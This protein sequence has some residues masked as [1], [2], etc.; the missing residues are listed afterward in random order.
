MA[1]II[2]YH[3]APSRS[4]MVLW[5]LEELGQPYEVR[6]LDMKAGENR[7]PAFLAINPMGK[8]PTIIHKGV[9][10]SEAPAICLHLADCYP[11]AGL[12]VPPDD[13]RRGPM[14]QW[15]FFG[16]GCVEPAAIDKAMERPPVRESMAGWGSYKDVMDTLEKGIGAARPWLTGETFTVADL[17]IGAQLRWGMMFGTIEKRP[18]FE[19][20]VARIAARPAALRAMQR[21]QAFNPAGMPAG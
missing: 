13:P 17:Y 10:I 16:T 11:E 2:L 20:Y 3:I 14:L 1:D 19:D 7:Q 21:D 8:V 12:S 5:L 18:G 15:L 9:T 6:L 4:S